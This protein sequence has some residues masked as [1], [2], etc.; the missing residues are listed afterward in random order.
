MFFFVK[1]G[2]MVYSPAMTFLK[3]DKKR[4]NHFENKDGEQ[5]I[6]QG[7]NAIEMNN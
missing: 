7:R 2:R 3:R 5:N 6:A 4:D 1:G